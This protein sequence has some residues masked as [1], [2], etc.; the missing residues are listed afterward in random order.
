MLFS[1]EVIPAV[2]VGCDVV[3]EQRF[4][5]Q[6]IGI[7]LLEEL[8]AGRLVLAEHPE[9]ELAHLL[10]GLQD[11]GDLQAAVE[12]HL[13]LARRHYWSF[14]EQDAPERPLLVGQVVAAAHPE[15]VL[16]V[17]VVGE[18]DL[19]RRRDQREKTSC[20]YRD[21]STVNDDMLLFNTHTVT[22]IQT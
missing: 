9:S 10:H 5:V 17:R 2:L 8:V 7:R 11:V 3:R 18:Q 15:D 16:E 21:T 12:A 19:R 22:G 13:D 1:K 20:S 14:G 4:I 6:L